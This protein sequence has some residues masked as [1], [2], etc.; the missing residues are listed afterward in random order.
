MEINNLKLE[1]IKQIRLII[2]TH[3]QD[4][5]NYEI[6]RDAVRQ[7]LEMTDEQIRFEQ[8]KTPKN[9]HFPYNGE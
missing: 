9:Q 2:N 7:R 8:L 1:T 3:L 5:S 6:I 4:C